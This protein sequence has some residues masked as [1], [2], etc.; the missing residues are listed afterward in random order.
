MMTHTMPPITPGSPPNLAPPMHFH[1]Y[2]KEEFHVVSG[3]ARF[4]LE[5][6]TH[7][8]NE[9]G[10]FEIPVGAY[11]RFENASLTDDLVIQVRLDEQDWVQE[12]SSLC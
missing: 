11:H 2:Q 10:I 12:V 3:R 1:M 8:R 9:D 4:H 5:G 7:E 6:L